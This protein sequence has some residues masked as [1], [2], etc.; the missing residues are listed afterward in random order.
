[1]D[2]IK[3]GRIPADGIDDRKIKYKGIVMEHTNDGGPAFPASGDE[4]MQCADGSR[5]L[6]SEY[7]IQGE[8]GMTLRDYFAA[9]AM[10][11]D[12]ANSA[13]GSFGMTHDLSTAARLYYRMADEMLKAKSTPSKEVVSPVTPI[14]VQRDI[15]DFEE[16]RQRLDTTGHVSIGNLLQGVIAGFGVVILAWLIVI[17]AWRFVSWMFDGVI[18]D[19]LR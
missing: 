18:A 11:G 3:L 19:S 1:M 12:W 10:Q 7:G 4:F 17:A 9:K 6:K 16:N 13:D 2:E 8:S 15:S 14:H 5:R